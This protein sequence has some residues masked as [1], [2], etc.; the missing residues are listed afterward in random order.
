MLLLH[1]CVR[2]H[3]K[4]LIELQLRGTDPINIMTVKISSNTHFYSTTVVWKYFVIKK[5]SWAVIS[6]KI[7]KQIITTISSYVTMI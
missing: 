4:L 2:E 3:R 1:V 7:F 5:F 6:M